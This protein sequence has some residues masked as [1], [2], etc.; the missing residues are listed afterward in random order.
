MT[1]RFESHPEYD[2]WWALSD[3]AGLRTMRIVKAAGGSERLFLMERDELLGLEGVSDKIAEYII[4]RRKAWDHGAA[5]DRLI[6]RGIR[7]LPFTDPAYPKRLL[8]TNNHPF[9]LFVKGD[10]PRED[11]PAVAVI[12]SR[13][14]SEYGRACA[15]YFAAGL[16]EC[17]VDVLSG[18]AIG[19]DGI[20]QQSA[21]QSGGSSYAVLGCGPDLCYPRANEKLYRMLC[22]HG[23]LLSE[24]G[25]GVAAQAWHFPARNRILA[26]L[27]DIV[28]VIEA[29][30]KSGTLITVDMA[31]DAGRDVMIVP[32]RIT[33]PMSV[34]IIR[35][36]HAGATPASCVE[37]VL[38]VLSGK[39]FSLTEN[40]ETHPGRMDDENKL[41]LESD[42]DLVYSCLDLYARSAE[43]VME[44]TKLPARE[45]LRIMT[46]L[47]LKGLIRETGKGYYIRTILI[48]EGGNG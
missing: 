22:E 47:D 24:Y 11:R 7:F 46:Q 45:L 21:L 12:G 17:G 10:L 33:D 40:G 5:S 44:R 41:P 23:G 6:K 2:L 43:E 9:A 34:G 38:N 3:K 36:W 31:L 26:G 16:A 30:E 19:I 18:M 15:A 20:A 8:M 39:G 4:Y 27:S 1:G 37:D 14:C 13:E 25:P 32:G 35:L 28:L 29:R 48:P 42:E